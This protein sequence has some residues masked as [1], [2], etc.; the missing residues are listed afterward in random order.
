[1]DCC[2]FDKNQKELSKKEETKNQKPLPLFASGILVGAISGAI[3]F[4]GFYNFQKQK[5]SSL[6]A[7]INVPQE[8]AAYL[9]FKEIK[10]SFVPSGIPEIYGKELNVSFD[11]VQ[12]AINKVAPLDPTYGQKKISLSGDELNRYIDVG[13]KIACEFCCGVK[14][15]VFENGEAACGCAHSQMMRGLTAYLIKNHPEV[16]N[17]KILEEL[18]KWKRVYFP[19]QSLSQELERLAKS[20]EP[21]IDQILK[22]FPDFLPQM[23]GG[24]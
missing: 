7:N 4:Y 16:S 18:T 19:K 10:S 17:E 13:S 14:T 1:M 21:G 8:A 11:Q 20:G 22:E 15:L 6:E 3:L 23:V 2:N 9:K 24:C 5:I 12:D